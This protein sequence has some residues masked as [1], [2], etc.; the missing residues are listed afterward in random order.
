MTIPIYKNKFRSKS[1][2]TPK[3]F[4]HYSI[5]IKGRKINQK[6][7]PES[8]ILLYSKTLLKHIKRRY[9]LKK[10]EFTGGEFYLFTERNKT[11]AILGNFGVGGPTVS[12]VMEELAELGIKNFISIG[13]A[14][15]LQPDVK[16][17]SFVLCT[18]ALRDEGTSYH[19]LPPSK[20]IYPSKMLFNKIKRTFGKLG[21]N[22]IEGP[23]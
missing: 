20:Y 17:G 15:S 23:T 10:V 16:L 14:G 5:K 8:V 12:I 11:I 18:K 7:I 22:Y 21:I 19:Y 9:K 3:K 2:I 4:L 1:F 6:Q 13:T